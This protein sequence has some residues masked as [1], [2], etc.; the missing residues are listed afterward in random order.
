M[1]E[2]PTSALT[3]ATVSGNGLF[4]TLMRAAKAHLEQEFAQNRI[5]GP[6]YSQVYLGSLTQILQTSATFLLEQR[7]TALEEEMLAAQIAETNARVLL[8]N[9][10]TALAEQQKLNAENEWKLLDE[11]RAKMV[12]ETALINEQVLNAQADRDILEQQKLKITAEVAVMQ[13]RVLTAPVERE[14]MEA[15]RD[16]ALIEVEMAG[17]QKTKLS[18]ENLL[19][20]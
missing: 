14:L 7:K 17:V 5:R 6:E 20:I 19:I 3:E 9:A 4:D 16:K 1:S 10:Q 15:Q 13:E 8:V 2:I 18:S 12:A 11:Q